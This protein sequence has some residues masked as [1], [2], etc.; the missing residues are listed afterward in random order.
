MPDSPPHQIAVR[1]A[2]PGYLTGFELDGLHPI[3]EPADEFATKTRLLDAAVRL[4]ADHGYEASSM[5]ELAGEVGVKAPAIY[6]HFDSKLDVLVTAIDYSVADF[7][8]TV[9][10]GLEEVPADQRLYELLRRHVMYKTTDVA[11]ARAHDKL[12]DA[13][14]MRRVL[15]PAD[16]QRIAGALN[17]YRNIIRD[18]V[19]LAEPT[20]GDDPGVDLPVLV[21]ALVAL[22]DTVSAWFRPEGTLTAEAVAEQCGSIA[23]RMVST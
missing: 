7:L 9:L 4:F 14:F 21:S 13:D 8:R 5:R 3:A 22:C 19:I 2:A 18:L 1:S 23:R 10:P 16:Y 17:G 20:A 15:P 6:N 11:F 12:L